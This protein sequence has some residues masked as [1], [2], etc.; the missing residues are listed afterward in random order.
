MQ[1]ILACENRIVATLLEGGRLSDA[2][3][4]Q[5][6]LEVETCGLPILSDMK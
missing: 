4:L 1:A 5:A 2:E 6:R 3:L